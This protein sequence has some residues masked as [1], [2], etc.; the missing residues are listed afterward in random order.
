[1]PRETIAINVSTL[2]IYEAGAVFLSCVAY[3]DSENERQKFYMALCRETIIQMANQDGDWAWQPQSIKPGFFI[4]GDQTAEKAI[5]K[6]FELLKKRIAAGHRYFM[7]F[8]LE[9]WN[10]PNLRVHGFEPKVTNMA[11]LAATDLQ[12]GD[13]AGKNV[14]RRIFTPSRPVLHAGAALSCLTQAEYRAA[15]PQGEQNAVRNLLHDSVKLSEVVQLAEIF[16]LTLSV[17]EKPKI[18]EE[19]TIE[20]RV[21]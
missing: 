2:P 11:I 1:M 4:I 17:M 15:P 7:P 14:M 21:A 5:N 8:I 19:E 6:G 18:K 3:P 13:D 16:R 10:D 12:W 9:R 20:F